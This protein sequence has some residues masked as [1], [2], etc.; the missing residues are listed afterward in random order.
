MH[1]KTPLDEVD[2]LASSDNRVEVLETLASE[3]L[4]RAALHDRTGIS[5]PTLGRILDGFQARGWIMK[6]GQE[7]RIS[8]LGALLAAEFRALLETVETI[9]RLAELGSVLP[10][11]TMEFDFRAFRDAT[12]TLPRAPDVFAHIRRVEELVEDANDVRTLSGNIYLDAIP[13]Q[14]DLVFTG[15][16][17]EVIISGDALDIALS[18]PETVAVMRE[19][20]DAEGMAVYRYDGEVACSLGLIDDRAF[21]LPYDDHRVP[22]ALIET[23]NETIFEWVVATLDAHREASRRVTVDDLPS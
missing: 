22:C 14:R 13:K 10:T 20:L 9:D 18:H 21:I 17:Q 12:F 8:R 7:Y 2:Y 19:V 1:S 11:E 4:T 5:Q 3:P 6:R 15:Q 23:E 16:R